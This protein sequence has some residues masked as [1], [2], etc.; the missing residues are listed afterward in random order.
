MKPLN[1]KERTIAY[2]Q[3]LVL[4]IT[5]LV[6]WTV[7]VFFDYR[8]KAKDYEVLKQENKKLKESSISSA[9]LPHQIDSLKGEIL[10]W[11]KMTETDY[12]DAKGMM[13]TELKVNFTGTDSTEL[14]KIKNS[15]ADVLKQ[16]MFK[17]GA[18][19]REGQKSSLVNEKSSEIK[20]LQKKLDDLKDEFRDYQRVHY[21]DC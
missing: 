19:I 8:I 16:L 14:S 20:D 13:M 4:S 7:A 11:Q 9:N 21:C 15:V 10:S 3:F 17:M 5:F 1:D 6:V 2:F 18:S 12:T